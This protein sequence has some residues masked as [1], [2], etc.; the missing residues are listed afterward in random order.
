LVREVVQAVIVV[1]FIVSLNVTVPVCGT[2]VPG[3]P[4]PVFAGT[5][6]PLKATFTLMPTGLLELLPALEEAVVAVGALDTV[7]DTLRAEE[8]ALK[9]ESPL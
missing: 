3:Y 2:A 1:P 9:F 8:P 5:T 4:E 7:C 6:V